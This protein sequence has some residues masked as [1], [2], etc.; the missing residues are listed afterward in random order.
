MGEPVSI[1]GFDVQ[2]EKVTG[3]LGPN[4]AEMSTTMRMMLGLDQP[5]SGEALI[6]VL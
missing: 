5:T 1:L 2:L 3:F 4:R 6:L